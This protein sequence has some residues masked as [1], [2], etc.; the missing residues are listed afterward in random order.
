MKWNKYPKKSPEDGE[1]CLIAFYIMPWGSEAGY[2]YN[3][4]T[5]LNGMFRTWERERIIENVSHW[6]AL[7]PDP[8]QMIDIDEEMRK[9]REGFAYRKRDE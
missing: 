1:E 8:D 7:P 3:L 6:M 2:A 9:F 4:A 5:Y